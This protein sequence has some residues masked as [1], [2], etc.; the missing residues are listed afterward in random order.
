MQLSIGKLAA[1]SISLLIAVA[2]I[3]T[4]TGLYVLQT[5]YRTLENRHEAEARDA[6]R[7]A[8][9][10]LHNEIRFYQG[11]LQLMAANP[12]VS[13]LIEFGNT[14][15]ITRWSQAVG[16]M[17]P[18]TLGTALVSPDGITFNDP[19]SL[20][21]GPA[22]Q[23][24]MQDVSQGIVVDYPMLH[25]DVAGLEH[26]DLLSTVTAPTGENAGAL[27]VSFRRSVLE[28]PLRGMMREGDHFLLLDKSG[29]EKMSVGMADDTGNVGVHRAP[30]ADT[31]WELVLNRPMPAPAASLMGLVIA[32]TLILV[33]VG[34]LVF[35]LVHMMLGRFR[36][37]MARVHRALEDVLEGRYQTSSAPTAIKEVG[38]LLPDIEKL[39]LRIQQQ[40]DKLHHQSLSDP[41][42]GVFNRRYF[43]LM[44]AHLHEQ[45]QR[46]SPA[47][48]AVIDLNDFKI[49][50]DEFGH[51]E[52]DRVL[53]QMAA[54]LQ[55]RVRATDI[56]V[57]LGGDEFALLLT[58]MG[59]D[60]LEDWLAALVHDHDHR[61][62]ENGHSGTAF[63][64]FSIG[65]AQIDAKAY[66]SPADV[67]N[68]ADGAMYAIKQRRQIRHSRF[69]IAR[70]GNVT[71][72]TRLS[73]AL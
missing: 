18:G 11:I 43:D 50:N 48:L 3:T 47:T 55:S 33:A 67:F 24:D 31:S 25:T 21:V 36:S 64:Q 13:D 34:L 69:A 52:G 35:I 14:S 27:F 8:A 56:V 53:R 5:N 4:G 70:I 1:L 23:A 7:N 65:V 16:R 10:A 19:L 66:P 58:N 63:C 40:S 60:V 54:Y 15:E 44:L 37:D 38:I 22:C 20:R 73:A 57:R 9:T 28:G 12:E 72:I 46:Q 26:F 45:S 30:I 2:I 39:A 32:D 51:P 68:A 71:P 62:L 61:M 49:L 41:L 6:V 29:R 17:L 59:G 42:T